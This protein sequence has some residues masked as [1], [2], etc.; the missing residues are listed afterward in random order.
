VGPAHPEERPP[1]LITGV[2]QV[3]TKVF[4]SMSIRYEQQ[5]NKNDF[6]VAYHTPGDY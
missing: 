6:L 1:R 4:M 2:G 3:C 5:D